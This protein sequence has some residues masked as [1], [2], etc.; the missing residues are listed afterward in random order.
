MQKSDILVNSYMGNILVMLEKYGYKITAV[1]YAHDMGFRQLS[2]S[3]YPLHHLP[4]GGELKG[5]DD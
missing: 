1:F 4:H 5:K 3:I 2:F